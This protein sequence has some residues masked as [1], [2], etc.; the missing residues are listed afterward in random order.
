MR[1]EGRREERTT[2]S[3]LSVWTKCGA[4]S[5]ARALCFVVVA[6]GLYPPPV[7]SPDYTPERGVQCRRR[8][9]SERTNECVHTPESF[10]RWRAKRHYLNPVAFRLFI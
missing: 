4:P 2:P 8:R 7:P 1:V 5:Q 9:I 10:I 6:Q 3:D